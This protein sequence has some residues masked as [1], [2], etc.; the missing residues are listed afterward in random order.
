MD[1]GSTPL[2]STTS[3]RG[4]QSEH[5]PMHVVKLPTRACLVLTD[6]GDKYVKH[7]TIN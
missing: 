3:R 2:T 5:Q 4:V 6:R 7:Y 1:R